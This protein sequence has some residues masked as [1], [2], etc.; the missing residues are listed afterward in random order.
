MGFRRVFYWSEKGNGSMTVTS[1]VSFCRVLCLLFALSGCARA[2]LTQMQA[3]GAEYYRQFTK[4]QDL[5]GR[6]DLAQAAAVYEQLTRAYPDDVEVW[7]AL[8]DA[9]AGSKQY[10]AGAEAFEQAV[11]RGRERRGHRRRGAPATGPRCG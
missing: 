1:S 9:R 3:L 4:A 2:Q 8:G 7:I 11:A 5:A 10:R 6:N